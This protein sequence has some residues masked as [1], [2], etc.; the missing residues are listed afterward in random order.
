MSLLPNIASF[1]AKCSL[2]NTRNSDLLKRHAT[3]HDS[4]Q[5]GGKRQ[6]SSPPP[7][8]RVAQACAA[9]AA[10][11]LKCDQKKPCKR[12]QQK[13]IVC[14]F[15]PARA[16]DRRPSQ[17]AALKGKHAILYGQVPHAWLTSL[18][19]EHQFVDSDKRQIIVDAAAPSQP[20]PMENFNQ[21]FL[22]GPMQL[23]THVTFQAR[24]K[25]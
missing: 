22:Q 12:C 6:K 16:Q 10:V 25:T 15:P 5:G 17:S 20:P 3:C 7:R 4:D 19:I 11:K 14:E 13:Q 1:A 2:S 18:H 21:H 24:Q 9:C 8:S 23:S